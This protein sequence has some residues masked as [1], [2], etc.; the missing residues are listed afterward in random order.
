VLELWQ[1]E[2]LLSPSLFPTL[3]S[4]PYILAS[5]SSIKSLLLGWRDAPLGKV[6][7]EQA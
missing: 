5:G 3:I 4:A 6:L 1:R 2:R 7:E